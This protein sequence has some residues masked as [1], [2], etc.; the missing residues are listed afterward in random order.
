MLA[1]TLTPAASPGS[2]RTGRASRA[3]PGLPRGG[4]APCWPGTSRSTSPSTVRS[5]RLSCESSAAPKSVSQRTGSSVSIVRAPSGPSTANPWFWLVMSIRPVSRSLTGWFAPRW[6][7]GSLNVSRPTARQSSWWPRQMPQ[8]GTR[9][10]ELAHRFDDVVERRRVAGAVREEDRVGL[11]RHQVVGARPARVQLEVHAALAH[12]AD[13]RALDAGV[14][15][16]HAR[17]VALE[18]H[19]LARASP[20]TRGRAR[21]SAARRRSRRARPPRRC[22]PGRSRRASSPCRGCGARARACRRR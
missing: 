6:P 16:D 15:R 9:A 14:D 17:A 20:R 8:T 5:Y 22:R 1:S 4:T 7:N 21:S 2:G 10:D 3:A 13:D 19:R 12:V 18:D 11:A